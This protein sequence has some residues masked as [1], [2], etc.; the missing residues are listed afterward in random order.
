MMRE[1]PQVQ[2]PFLSIQSKNILLDVKNEI[3]LNLEVFHSKIA[4]HSFGFNI[5]E[6]S[7]MNEHLQ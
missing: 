5:E 4:A 2:P 6:H 3:A 1:N 7:T